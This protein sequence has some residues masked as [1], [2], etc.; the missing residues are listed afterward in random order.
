M[1]GVDRCVGF[2]Q[3]VRPVATGIHRVATKAT[4]RFG[5]RCHHLEGV[6]SIVHISRR[7]RAGHRRCTHRI[8]I[9]R[10]GHIS[11]HVARNHRRIIGAR[12]VDGDGL[13]RSAINTGHRQ[14]VSH[15]LTLRQRISCTAGGVVQG[16]GP[17]TGG[18][19]KGKRAIGAQQVTGRR[20]GKHGLAIIDIRNLQV[21]A[22]V[23]LAFVER[24]RGHTTDRGTVVGA[25]HRNCQGSGI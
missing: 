17:I 19:V 25:G 21:A 7:H 18:F 10:F 1:Q 5:A 20:R 23:R 4:N 22:H 3:Y 9:A 16:V 12:D 11:G 15:L 24:L 6:V 13:G 8:R 14:G 2:V